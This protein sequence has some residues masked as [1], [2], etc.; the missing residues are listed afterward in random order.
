MYSS[1]TVTCSG[2]EPP[3]LTR[4][5]FTNPCHCVPWNMQPNFP[6]FFT[7]L[8]DLCTSQPWLK[9]S[10]LKNDAT[11]LKRLSRGICPF[12]HF[13]WLTGQ[14]NVDVTSCCGQSLLI[15]N[16]I[17]Q[18]PLLEVQ[19]LLC[20]TLSLLLEGRGFNQSH[21]DFSTR[22]AFTSPNNQLSSCSAVLIPM[23]LNHVSSPACSLDG[24][25]FYIQ[26]HTFHKYFCQRGLRVKSRKTTRSKVKWGTCSHTRHTTRLII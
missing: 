14:E 16:I 18:P 2:P 22:H 17:T 12:S 5:P 8:K 4:L 24:S 26:Q 15:L 19:H 13:R 20:S 1:A 25:F 10:F 6:V 11:F 23:L 3:E 9:P 21:G 7:L